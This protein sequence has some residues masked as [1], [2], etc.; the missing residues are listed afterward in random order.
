MVALLGVREFVDAAL[1]G[2]HLL[3]ERRDTDDELRHG[4]VRAWWGFGRI[5]AVGRHGRRHWLAAGLGLQLLQLLQ[6]LAQLEDLV[7]QL[8]AFVAL[9]LGQCRG[10]QQRCHDGEDGRFHA[11]SF[12]QDRLFQAGAGSFKRSPCGG[13]PGTKKVQ[14]LGPWTSFHASR[15]RRGAPH[16]GA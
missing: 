3:L 13:P 15:N 5:A 7:L 9:D 2:A 6:L 4:V 8:D 11:I 1:Q 12:R 16:S 10:C 14:E